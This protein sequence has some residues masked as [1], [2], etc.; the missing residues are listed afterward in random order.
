M[1]GDMLERVAG[2]LKGQLE[3]VPTVVLRVVGE[4]AES[5]SRNFSRTSVR[6]RLEGASSKLSLRIELVCP[7]GSG[8]SSRKRE[9][10]D[11]S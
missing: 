7:T 6:E 1:L 4:D 2:P 3:E 10:L 11:R 5:D 8:K 9:S